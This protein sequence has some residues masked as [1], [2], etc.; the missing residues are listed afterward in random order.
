MQQVIA[1]DGVLLVRQKRHAV[2]SCLAA[3]SLPPLVMAHGHRIDEASR[4]IPTNRF[5]EFA[6]L[7]FSQLWRP[8]D[9]VVAHRS[10]QSAS[11]PSPE[12]RQFSRG[13]HPFWNHA[14]IAED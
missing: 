10:T 4:T 8:F 2:V 13:L 1:L 9:C 6:P 14:G 5:E 11:A 3:S 12:L 7:L